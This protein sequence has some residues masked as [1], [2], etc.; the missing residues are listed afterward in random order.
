M[1]NRGV[2][3]L[4]KQGKLGLAVSL[5]LLIFPCL[6]SATEDYD[7]QHNGYPA[8]DPSQPNEYATYMHTEA[9]VGI[10][11][12][13]ESGVPLKVHGDLRA[14]GICDENGENCK[15]ISAGWNSA[16]G[17]GHSLDAAD[18]SA[19]NVVYVNNSGNVG[20]GTTNPTAG[21]DVVGSIQANGK[22]KLF[23]NDGGFKANIENPIAPADLA[24]TL[25]ST[26]K[27]NILENGDRNQL[28]LGFYANDDGGGS[29]DKRFFTSI[30]AIVE[31]PNN[32]TKKAGLRF[33]TNKSGAELERM[34]IDGDGNVGIGTNNPADI[35][36]VKGAG[37][38][39]IT[40]TDSNNNNRIYLQTDSGGQ[41]VLRMFNTGGDEKVR[42]YAA[43][44]QNNWISNGGNVGIGTNNPGDILT[45]KGAGNKGITVTDSNNNNRIFLQT[46]S[47][48]QGVLRMYNTGGEENVRIYAA[49]GQDNW[50]SNGGNVG[51][52]TNTPQS[53][54]AVNG[55]ITAKEI[56]VTETGW[57][58]FVFEETYELPSLDSVESHIKKHKHLPEIPSAQEV[59]EQGIAVSE[60]LN[61]QMQ[62]IE[63][64][65]LYLIE[66]KKENDQLKERVALL[67]DAINK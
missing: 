66:L 62:K 20:I 52:G 44:G 15:D 17:D 67:E 5:M 43:N 27:K 51:I 57:A 14:H 59:K 61:K 21:L 13:H 60:M 19:A 56:K 11:G 18:G 23:S 22:I 39:G 25:V 30:E 40:V 8:V 37:N 45:V 55:T 9:D 54:L 12:A 32:S 48:G 28:R 10:G 36:T 1:K 46:D 47:G 42:I 33:S 49:N 16:T 35:L 41:G 58:D 24:Q 38:K 2:V 65:T 4:L 7:W 31:D 63:E 34:R 3:N 29:P 50:I 6:S 53:K 26:L 64:M